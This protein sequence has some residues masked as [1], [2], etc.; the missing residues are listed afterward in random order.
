MNIIQTRHI[1]MNALNLP[2]HIADDIIYK[3]RGCSH[4]NAESIKDYWDYMNE[5][6]QAFTKINVF[7]EEYTNEDNEV[8]HRIAHT[9]EQVDY[10]L[11]HFPI[12]F[13]AEINNKIY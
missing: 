11:L 1:L 13:I 8:K 7:S 4:P 9:E 3:H 12:H 5:E 10:P 2:Y 6:Q